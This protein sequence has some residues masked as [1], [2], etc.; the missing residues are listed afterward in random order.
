M[1][2]LVADVGHMHATRQ[3]ARAPSAEARLVVT[4][5]SVFVFWTKLKQI[6]PAAVVEIDFLG[7]K[8]RSHLTIPLTLGEL[9][10]ALRA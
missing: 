2:E 5:S 8:F 6:D 3:C 10:D 9:L 1:H 7:C 4:V